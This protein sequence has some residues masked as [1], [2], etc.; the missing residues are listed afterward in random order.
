MTAD[1]LHRWFAVRNA[2][3]APLVTPVVI[4]LAVVLA[5]FPLGLVVADRGGRVSPELRREL[6]DRYRSWLIFIP[7]MFGPVLLG[8]A[9]TMA[10]VGLLSVLCYREFARATG[11]FRYTAT[12]GTVVAGIGA[13]TFAAADHWYAMFASLPPIFI[14]L[15]A[16]TAL[17]PDRPADY[18]QRV[19]LGVVAFLLFG[20]CL[21]HLSYLANDAAY[22]SILVWLVA[23]VEA[24]DIL[25]FCCGKLIGGPKLA[26]NT[27][28]NKTVGGAAGA[29]VCTTL[30]ATVLGRVGLAGTGVG[31]VGYLIP[32]GLLI[33]AA[34]QLGDLTLSSVKRNL[35]IKD[36][37][38]P[39]PATVACST[40]STACCSRP[41]RPSTSSATSTASAST[42][43]PAS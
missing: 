40:G 20:V 7:L 42:S 27:S 9:A 28:P 31:T 21:G 33:S 41:P 15:I 43:R 25:A 4:G 26:P 38:A 29:L 18:L 32:L 6:W 35:Q 34:A 22:R 2:F 36:W 19:S 39:S 30:L 11:L 23:C 5:A 13:V 12:S 24:N 17:L 3:A 16:A 37:A 8:A 1:T 10:A 14:A